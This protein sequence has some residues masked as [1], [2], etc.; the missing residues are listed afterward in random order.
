ME[1]G[2]WLARRRPGLI[3]VGL[4]NAWRDSRLTFEW[5]ESVLYSIADCMYTY[6][7]AWLVA[8]ELQGP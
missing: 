7:L 4:T 6:S 3:P 2:N 1:E 8:A 5:I